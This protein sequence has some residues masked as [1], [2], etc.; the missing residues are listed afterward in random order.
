M[1]K[2]EL[3][4]SIQSLRKQGKLFLIFGIILTIAGFLGAIIGGAVLGFNAAQG[5]QSPE[6][7]AEAM[8]KIMNS[9]AFLGLVAGMSTLANLGIAMIVLKFTMINIRVRA[10]TRTLESLEK[11]E[12]VDEQ[13]AE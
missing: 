1:N 5:A 2:E 7:L 8:A 10:R 12:K 13:P 3:A 11:E 6:E 9:P 4:R